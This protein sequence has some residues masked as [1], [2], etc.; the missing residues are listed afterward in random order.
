M[1]VTLYMAMTANGM[2][3]KADDDTSWV[4]ATEWKSFSRAI[5]RA[6]NMIIGRRTFEIMEKGGQF[7][8]LEKVKVMVTTHRTGL[9]SS[10]PN[11]TFT[12]RSPRDILTFLRKQGF[13]EA[14]VAGGGKLN[15]SFIKEGLINEIYLDIE[16]IVLGKGIRLFN[17]A[18][19]ESKLKL[20][21]TK[22]LSSNEMQLHYKVLK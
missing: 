2:I 20:L 15:S 12:D 8:V 3:A 5:N 18:D 10:N 19:F 11:V 7:A 21:G 4:S 9:R 1:K 13:K 17:E 16:P 6:G 14:L 22:E